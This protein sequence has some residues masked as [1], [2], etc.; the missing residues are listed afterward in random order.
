MQDRIIMSEYKIS[1]EEIKEA[2]KRSGYLLERR[3]SNMFRSLDYQ[4]VNSPTY[5]DIETQKKREYDVD[6]FK[7]LELNEFR[8][9]IRFICE[10]KNNAL[11][12]VFFEDDISYTTYANSINTSCQPEVI[13]TTLN[14]LGKVE[15]DEFLVST[16]YCTFKDV[17]SK[18]RNQQKYEPDWIAFHEDQQYE[19]F[20]QILKAS[21]YQ[22]DR[23]RRTLSISTIGNRDIEI[24][25]PLMIFQGEPHKLL[26]I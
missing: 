12:V 5:I 20:N 3:V 26:N 15:Q 9:T 14:R 19:A 21:Q 1:I 18:R 25:Y 8:Y 17:N 10:C 2:L 6:A 16:Q 24:I 23:S 13:A 22:I 11:P 7:Y 4:P